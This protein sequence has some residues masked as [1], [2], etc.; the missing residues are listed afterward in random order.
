MASA[1]DPSRFIAAEASRG[2]TIATLAAPDQSVAGWSVEAK[3]FSLGNN[4]PAVAGIAALA[5]KGLENREWFADL[6]HFTER[7]CPDGVA[8]D[9]WDEL[10]GEAW[11]LARDW[12]DIAIAAGWTSI[13]LFGCNP[14]PSARR[15]DRD[16]LVMTIVGLRSATRILSID[17]DAA[18]LETADLSRSIL[19]KRRHPAAGSVLL[20]QA[21]SQE[22][23]P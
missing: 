7:P 18:T 21:Y 19:R 10:T 3:S 22:G 20:W 2:A 12:S 13:D 6:R 8:P 17:A 4:P 14:V 9:F 23:G 15:V 16:G 1:F 11:T 5:A